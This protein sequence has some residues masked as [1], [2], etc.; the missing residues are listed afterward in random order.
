[1]SYSQAY[2]YNKIVDKK[3]QKKTVHILFLMLY[4]IN[5]L[6][7][8]CP[9]W[10]ASPL[11]RFISVDKWGMVWLTLSIISM[12]CIGGLILITHRLV[13]KNIITLLI[14][15][16]YFFY[17]LSIVFNGF[18][19]GGFAI[20]GIPISFLVFF[21]ICKKYKF[22]VIHLKI[23]NIVI[24]IWAIAPIILLLNPA[25][26]ISFFTAPAGNIMT[27]SGFA[28]HRNFYG[29]IV[30]LSLILLYFSNFGIIKKIICLI[31]IFL[32]IYL[33]SCRT[34]LV[35]LIL[36]FGYLIFSNDS[37]SKKIKSFLICGGIVISC[38]GYWIMTDPEYS[39]RNMDNNDDREELYTSFID[40]IFEKPLLGYGENV[41]YTSQTFPE[42][43]PAHNFILQTSANYGIPTMIMWCLLLLAVFYYGSPFIRLI[44]VYLLM[45]G[46]TQ[47]YWGFGVFSAHIIVSLF[48]AHLLDS[49]LH[50]FSNRF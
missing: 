39:L 1:M 30:G 50:S 12:I 34:L 37:I 15:L 9:S 38:S 27:F 31:P 24:L 35:S 19:S 22:N 17:L 40:V 7:I 21:V 8:L 14:L 5:L 20:L 36:T 16:S 18:R 32:G 13:S 48:I 2:K 4:Y 46:L 23:T 42:G 49:N 47:P 6:I 26:R 10:S 11:Y 25:I 29:F 43:A 41:T 28:I 44:L 33:S 45:W 3:R